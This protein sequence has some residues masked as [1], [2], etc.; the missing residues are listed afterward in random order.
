MFRSQ[1]D[2]LVEAVRVGEGWH[3]QQPVA[4]PGDDVNLNSIASTLANLTSETTIES[5]A[6]AEVYGLGSDSRR[7]QFR[8]GDKSFTLQ[9]GDEAPV[10]GN[11]YVARD[12]APDEVLTIAA[13]RVSSFDRDLDALRD[14]R[15]LSFD[16]ARVER[17]VAG[18]PGGTVTVEKRESGWVITNPT[19]IAGPADEKTIDDLLSDVAFLRA[20]GFDDDPQAALDAMAKDSYFTV[21]LGLTEQADAPLEVGLSVT[22]DN[23]IENYVVRGGHP[24]ALY[25]VPRARIDGFPRDAFAYRFKDVSNFEASAVSAFEISFQAPSGVRSSEPET[26]RVN[27]TDDG[28]ASTETRG[29]PAK[30][31]R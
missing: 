18:W 5:P 27:R 28:W 21:R 9:I 16:R 29:V 8:V 19:A 23:D 14:R 30:P 12:D 20:E 2:Q 6:A 11:I 25:R 10:G 24:G 26:V 1:D 22:S 4:F 13:F 17:V 31:Q 7:I 3:L 15:V